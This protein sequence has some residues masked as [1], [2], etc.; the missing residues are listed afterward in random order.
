MSAKEKE[1]N[2]EA[3]YYI[4]EMMINGWDGPKNH[5][6]DQK[7]P[8]F[9][10]NHWDILKKQER[11]KARNGKENFVFYKIDTEKNI[12]SSGIEKAYNINNFLRLK[13]TGRDS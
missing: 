1:L 13:K 6:I 10:G 5:I 7:L 4:S 8:R 9:P 11:E 12:S 2:I 3:L